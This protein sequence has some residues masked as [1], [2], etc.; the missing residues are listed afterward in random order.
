M[1]ITPT[2]FLRA[3]EHRIVRKKLWQHLLLRR[4]TSM[5]DDEFRKLFRFSKAGSTFCESFHAS[6]RLRF[7]FHPRNQKDF[8][9][10]LLTR[11]QSMESIL[12]E[13]DDVMHN[14]FETLGSGK[15]SLGDS[16]NWQKDFKSGLDWPLEPS[17]K[18]DVLD[19]SRPSDIKVPW[20]LSRFHQ[21]WWLGKAY[22]LTH[23]EQY[24]EKFRTL[25][26]DWLENNPPGRGV[27]WVLA[28]EASIRA[29]NWIAGYYFF[30]ESKSLSDEFWIR[31]WKSL[32]VHAIFIRNNL[33]Y[34]LPNGNHFL[35]NV[36]G[37]VFLGIF[38]QNASA[39]KEWLSL[40][41][42]S[43]QEE[44]DRQVYEDGVDWEKSI[45]YHRLMLEFFY[46]SAILCSLYN[47]KLPLS[48]RS[49]LEKMF[50]YTMHYMRPDGSV[51]NVGDGDD[52]RLFRFAMAEDV[53]DHRHALSVGAILFERSDFKEAA[54]KFYQDT[55]WLFGGEGFE[56]HQLLKP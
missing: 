25:I 31:F 36:V 32:Y 23:N 29:C 13:A 38:F 55:L 20:E 47:V 14:R 18:L 22:W 46:T 43:L 10:Q 12:E 39:G 40:G 53:T 7:F 42:R 4:S 27:N 54:G 50:E 34:A 28:M 15:V 24:A 41:V 35:S 44:M 48:F 2:S 21:V 1:V 33:E 37:L 16:I 51:P 3:V 30:C 19:L 5:T 52:G 11:G 26:E 6:I 9:L 56:K 49:R 17:W 45:S 8:F